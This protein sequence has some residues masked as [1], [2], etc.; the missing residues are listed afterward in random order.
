MN[1]RALTSVS[2][3]GLACLP[4]MLA[5][6]TGCL[7][8]PLGSV[9]LAVAAGG[10]I[11]L[12]LALGGALIIAFSAQRG[13]PHALVGAL[14]SFTLRIGGVFVSA[15][16]LGTSA[17]VILTTLCCCLGATVIIEMLS[18]WMQVMRRAHTA[19]PQESARA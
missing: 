9:W 3:I 17:T 10:A 18:G 19:V 7:L 12:A 5:A 11:A 6:A 16:V 1:P 8:S 4:C 14:L 15:D 13:L 2:Q